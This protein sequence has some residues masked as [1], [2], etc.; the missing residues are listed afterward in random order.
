MG[1]Q[2]RNDGLC[3][4]SWDRRHPEV[5]SE[6][7]LGRWE[8]KRTG[9]PGSGH[10]IVRGQTCGKAEPPDWLQGHLPRAWCGSPHRRCPARN[11]CYTLLTARQCSPKWDH[12]SHS[13]TDGHIPRAKCFM[14]PPGKTRR[15]GAT[16]CSGHQPQPLSLC[17]ESKPLGLPLVVLSHDRC[18]LL[19]A[20]CMQA[21]QWVIHVHRTIKHS[22]QPGEE[23]VISPFD[24]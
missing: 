20:Y 10:S 14:G 17:F 15:R 9:I 2:K 3:W 13:N 24:S 5:A 21:R 11:F 7:G 12:S 19:S 22:Q 23:G 1:A 6:L 4:G 18:H 8:G 16:C